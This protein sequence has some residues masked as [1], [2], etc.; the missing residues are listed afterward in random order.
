M[1]DCPDCGNPMTLLLESYVCDW[2]DGLVADEWGNDDEQITLPMNF[3]LAP[4][5]ID[6]DFSSIVDDDSDLIDED[7]V[8]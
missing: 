2:C 7:P 3:N 5:Y 6:L 8:D 4:G 1:R